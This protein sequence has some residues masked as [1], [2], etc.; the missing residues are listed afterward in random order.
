MDT[1]S[2]LAM[3]SRQLMGENIGDYA[4]KNLSDLLE[5]EAVGGSS[6]PYD[7]Y[8]EMQFA[9]DEKSVNPHFWMIGTR[10]TQADQT[11]PIT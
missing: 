6:I 1:G 2:Q 10:S 7:G 4:L 5:V 11:I 9:C 3:V 8:V